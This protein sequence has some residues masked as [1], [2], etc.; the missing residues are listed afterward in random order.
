M[1]VFT[2]TLGVT[3]HTDAGTITSTS[4]SYTGDSEENLDVAVPANTTNKEYDLTCI[5]ADLKSLVLYSD[6]AMTIKTNSSGTPQETI[7]LAAKSQLVW[8]TDSAMAKP[9]SANVTKIF[10]TTGAIPATANLRIRLLTTVAV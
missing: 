4:S 9:F 1:T 6:Q 3:Y 10:V 5:A 2:H 7:V 8:N